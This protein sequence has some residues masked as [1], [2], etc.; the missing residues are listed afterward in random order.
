MVGRRQFNGRQEDVA[1]LK[2]AQDVTGHVFEVRR[3]RPVGTNLAIGSATRWGDQV[4]LTQGKIILKRREGGVPIIY[5]NL[6]GA[7]GAS[8]SAIWLMMPDGWSGSCRSGL[9]LRM[10]W[11]EHL[12][13]G[14]WGELS[15]WWGPA[16]EEGSVSRISS[17]RRLCPRM[18]SNTR[19]NSDSDSTPELRLPRRAPLLRRLQIRRAMRKGGAPDIT[20]VVVSN[21]AAGVITL[22]VTTVA[23]IVDTSLLGIDLDTDSN[24][25]TGSAGAEYSLVAGTRGFGLLKWD[26]TKFVEVAA[27]SLSSTRTG[28]VV[29]FRINRLDI[30]NPGAF[31]LVVSQQCST[32]P[33]TIWVRTTRRRR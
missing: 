21:D 24:P 16:A 29:T 17:W 31:G 4:S 8:G 26:G 2:L 27:A 19:S 33:T 22:Q 14:G 12:R 5:V 11:S 28:N 9:E 30:G 25:A 23:P 7:E 20:Q 3:R 6:L 18:R 32:G 13:R 15:A 10:Y 1:T